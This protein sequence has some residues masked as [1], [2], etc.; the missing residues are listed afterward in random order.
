MTLNTVKERVCNVE[1]LGIA[2]GGAAPVKLV[3]DIS[4][5]ILKGDYFALVGESGS[6]KSITCHSM[7][8]L[9]PF[10][11]QIEGRITIDGADV[12][13][14]GG[15]QLRQFRRKSVGMVFQ[16]PLAALNPVRTIGSQMLETLKLYFP[17]AR[18]DELRSRAIEALKGVH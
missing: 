12:W 17:Q 4:F 1:H 7:M 18:P 9:L 10:T 8:R 13:S 3:D 6:G 15:Q 2:I 11:P 14:L 5:E 16:D